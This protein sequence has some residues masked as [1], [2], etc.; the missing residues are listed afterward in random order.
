M[1]MSRQGS[2]GTVHNLKSSKVSD[3]LRYQKPKKAN[4]RSEE[5]KLRL[6]RASPS[7]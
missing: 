2:G 6:K 7:L 3:F 1:Q 5:E 4:A